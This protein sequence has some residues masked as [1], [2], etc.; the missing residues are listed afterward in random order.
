[1]EAHPYKVPD[2]SLETES[3]FCRTCGSPIAPSAETCRH[4][5]TSQHLNSKKKLTAGFLALFLGGLGIHR[6][7]L[8]QWWGIFYT[9]FWATGIPS[10]IS[11][12][13]AVV[14]FCTSDSRWNA[15]YSRTAGSSWVL[16]VGATIAFLILTGL[17]AARAIPAYHDYVE[18]AKA[19]QAE[20]QQQH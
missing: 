12:V 10:V 2:A 18:R 5:K 19:K 17:I 16:A 15:K 8:G 3:V 6:F 20:L 7:Y 9:M 4:C 14:F 11:L 1:M 13:E